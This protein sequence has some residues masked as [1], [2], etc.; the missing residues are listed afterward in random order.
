MYRRKYIGT[1]GWCPRER[2]SGKRTT[3]YLRGTASPFQFLAQLQQRGDTWVAVWKVE[4][5]MHNYPVSKEVY[6]KYPGIRQVPSKSVLMPGIE[7]LVETRAAP[8][9]ISVTLAPIQSTE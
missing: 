8:T 6:M 7:L 4:N 9:S 2:T 3:H 1:H 5:Y